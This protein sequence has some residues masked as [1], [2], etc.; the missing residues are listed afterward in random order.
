LTLAALR[1]LDAG[2]GYEI[3][4]ADVWMA[5]SHTMKAAEHLG[6]CDGVRERI[7]G[8]VARESFVFHVL[9]RELGLGAK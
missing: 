8:L 6:R 2:Y 4:A 7:R 3:T 9:G 1:W 5:Y